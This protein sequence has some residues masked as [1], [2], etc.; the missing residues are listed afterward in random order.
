MHT[1]TDKAKAQVQKLVSMQVTGSW[2]GWILRSSDQ[3]IPILTR[4]E[5]LL[6]GF[7]CYCACR[8]KKQL[9]SVCS[10]HVLL[11]HSGGLVT[12]PCISVHCMTY[13]D[14]VSAILLTHREVQQGPSFRHL[15]LKHE[16]AC[17]QIPG[18]RVRTATL[19]CLS[20]YKNEV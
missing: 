7:L 3:A 15:L 9:P 8:M 5:F 4:K 20:V 18:P 14:W 19:Y 2:Q 12:R 10:W 11:I 1:Q 6:C 17:Y 16:R 13:L